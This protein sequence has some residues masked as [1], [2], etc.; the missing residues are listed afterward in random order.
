MSRTSM[1]GNDVENVTKSLKSPRPVYYCNDNHC[2]Q[3]SFIIKP[4][5]PTK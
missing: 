4:S 1:D 5:A 3:T 2:M